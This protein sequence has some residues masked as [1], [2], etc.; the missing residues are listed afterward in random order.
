[1][2]NF[3]RLKIGQPIS[4]W[5]VIPCFN[6]ATHISAVID[7]VP[8]EISGIVAVNDASTDKTADTLNSLTAQKR[9]HI[10]HND[11]NLGVGGTTKRG[12]EFAFNN[13]A[14]VVVKLDGDGQ[15]DASLISALVAPIIDGRADYVKGNRFINTDQ[16]IAMPKLRLLGNIA[17]SFLTKLSSG[18]WEIFDPNNGFVAISR[19]AFSL[20]PVTKVDNRYFFE[21]DMLFRLHLARAV[22]QDIP[23]PTKYGTEISG[24]SETRAIFEFAY[25]HHRNFVKRILIEYY[26]RDFNLGSLQLPLGLCLGFF[27]AIYGVVNFLHFNSLQLETPTGTQIVVAMSLLSGLQLLLSFFA[28]DISNSPKKPIS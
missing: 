8:I 27:G 5:V 1:V 2:S 25:K 24:L 22:I 12:F 3:G 18:Y 14:D 19:N 13:G 16:V 10:L 6:V 20:I 28:F 4:I 23:I 15:M 17:L 26:L 9:L 21:S 11:K 7:S